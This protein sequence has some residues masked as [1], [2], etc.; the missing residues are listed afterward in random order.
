VVDWVEAAADATVQS[1]RAAGGEATA[2]VGD[3]S[4]AEVAE[5]MVASLHRDGTRR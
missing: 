3:A 5:D 1:V 2:Y 4:E